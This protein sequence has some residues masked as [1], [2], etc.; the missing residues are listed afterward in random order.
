MM[1]IKSRRAAEITAL[2]QAHGHE[3][4]AMLS[5]TV[6]HEMGED[7]ADLRRRLALAWRAMVTGAPWRRFKAR[8]GVVGTVRSLE[9][10]HGRHGYHPHLHVLLLFSSAEQTE[11]FAKNAAD[12]LAER[13]AAMVH[14]HIDGCRDCA[15]QRCERRKHE[16]LPGVGLVVSRC[17]RVGASYISKLGLEVS[18]PGRKR[19]RRGG[20]TPV[21]IAADA[22]DQSRPAARRARDAGLWRY[23]CK[24]MR[25][26]N[27]LTWSR[28][29]KA[30]YAI[31]ER[32]DWD[33]SAEEEAPAES[34]RIAS[35]TPPQWRAVRGLKVGANAAPY[36]LIEAAEKGGSDGAYRM[37]GLLLALDQLL[38]FARYLS[39]AGRRGKAD[40]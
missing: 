35:V 21:Q 19:G 2:V 33:L 1:S 40:P 18:D 29:L 34:V 20:R 28:G 6:R 22:V 16:P 32:A 7:L 17:P 30:R 5:L 24:T 8:C 13:W 25:G 3:K 14:R 23:Y 11:A 36:A 39:K 38:S 4:T 27:Q 10:T 15:G 9:L 37:V 26:A 12:W 31:E